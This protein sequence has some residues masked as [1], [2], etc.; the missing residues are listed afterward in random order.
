MHLRKDNIIIAIDCVQDWAI[1]LQQ[2]LTKVRQER[3][4][5]KLEHDRL[6]SELQ[7][8]HQA[9]QAEEKQRKLLD[10]CHCRKYIITVLS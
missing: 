5:L 3:D 4:S 6:T 10:V 9:L 8:T 2:Q 1:N 7:Q